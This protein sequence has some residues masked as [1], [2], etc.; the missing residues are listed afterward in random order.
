MLPEEIDALEEKAALLEQ[1]LGDPGHVGNDV[2]K[3]TELANQLDA[4]RRDIEE[5]QE[6]WFAIEEKREQL[7]Q[8]KP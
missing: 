3:I 6:L 4:A 1:Q 2:G 5:K 7:E 8:G